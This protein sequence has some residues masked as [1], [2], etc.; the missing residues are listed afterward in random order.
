MKNIT[1]LKRS[2]LKMPLKNST[3]VVKHFF[4]TMNIE[5][6]DNFVGQK[7]DEGW[8]LLDTK[9]VNLD[10]ANSLFTL[11]YIFEKEK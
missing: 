2:M 11:F 6:L 3:T 10:F 8:K 7:I 9:I 1:V 4:V 5:G